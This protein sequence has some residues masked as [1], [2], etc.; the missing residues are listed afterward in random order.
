MAVIEHKS[1]TAVTKINQERLQTMRSGFLYT[2]KQSAVFQTDTLSLDLVVGRVVKIL[3]MKSLGQVHPDFV[4]RDKNDVD[5]VFTQDEFLQF[6]I[7]LDEFM[8]GKI[9]ESWTKKAGL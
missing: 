9:I 3:A 4:W 1:P 6:F 2:G 5:H 8:E 7:A